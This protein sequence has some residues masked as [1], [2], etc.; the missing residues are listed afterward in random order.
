MLKRSQKR[1]EYAGFQKIL[2]KLAARPTTPSAAAVADF[3]RNLFEAA[4]QRGSCVHVRSRAV[5]RGS[6]QGRATRARRRRLV[7]RREH[8]RAD[9]AAGRDGGRY[10]V[11]GHFNNLVG[12]LRTKGLVD[13]PN[14]GGVMLTDA[15][16]GAERIQTAS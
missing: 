9:A 16:V 15:G 3:G 12:G 7:A 10:T 5:A 4:A 6:H 2:G 1:L 8:R 14:S 13:Y 11:N